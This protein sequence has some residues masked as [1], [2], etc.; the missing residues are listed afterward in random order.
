M[1]VTRSNKGKTLEAVP[2]SPKRVP[3]QDVVHHASKFIEVAAIVR[4]VREEVLPRF[5]GV[6]SRE[7]HALLQRSGEGPREASVEAIVDAE[8]ALERL[9]VSFDEQAH[10]LLDLT[11]V[12]D[13]LGLGVEAGTGAE[14]KDRV[15]LRPE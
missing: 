6:G 1:K 10:A 13:R 2:P 12:V 14:I 7:A 3:V 5:R 4:S 15:V 11:V 8:I 9:A